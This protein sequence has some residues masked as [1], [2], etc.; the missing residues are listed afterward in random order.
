MIGINLKNARR[1]LNFIDIK[2]SHGLD[3]RNLILKSELDF[4]LDL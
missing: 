2:K 3:F 1:K 4:E